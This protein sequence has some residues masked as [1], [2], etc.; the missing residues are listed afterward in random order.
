MDKK[1]DRQGKSSGALPPNDGSAADAAA[2]VVAVVPRAVR[3]GGRSGPR[4][5]HYVR[6]D[7]SSPCPMSTCHVCHSPQ[8]QRH[9]HQRH[10]L[11]AVGDRP[12]ACLF[13][14]PLKGV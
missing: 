6:C 13:P 5:A 3:D 1:R 2:R 4:N 9:F 14:Q 12:S 11:G 10:S 7:R 8:F